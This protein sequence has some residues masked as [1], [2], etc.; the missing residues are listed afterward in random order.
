MGGSTVL[1]QYSFTNVNLLQNLIAVL[2]LLYCLQKDARVYTKYLAHLLI[3]NP[4]RMRSRVTVSS[5]SVCVCVCVCYRSNC[6]S[7]DHCCPI[8]VP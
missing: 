7:V 6:S 3:I 8:V 5:L 1:S 2:L 4:L